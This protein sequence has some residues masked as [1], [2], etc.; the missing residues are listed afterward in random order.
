MSDRSTGSNSNGASTRAPPSFDEWH[1]LALESPFQNCDFGFKY[2]RVPISCPVRILGTALLLLALSTILS[3]QPSGPQSGSDLPGVALRKFH[4]ARTTAKQY[5]ALGQFAQAIPLLEKA[6]ILDPSNFE[7]GYD[8]GSAY[9]QTGQWDRARQEINRVVALHDSP[10]LHTLLGEIENKAG[11]R[12]AAAG[13]YQI[14]AQMEP[15]E[16]HIFDFGQ[17]LLTFNSDAAMTIF[18]YGVTKFPE[19][20][21]LRVGL[22]IAYYLYR[23]YDSAADT[24][25]QAVDMNPTDPRPIEFLGRIEVLSPE[26]FQQVN[27]RLET[28]LKLHP[29]N[30]LV[31][32]ELARN[33][34][35][36]PGKRPT[37]ED[38]VRGE[39]LLRQAIRL[40][41]RLADAYF[42]LGLI[43]EDKGQKIEARMLYENA[44]RLDASQARFHYR[45]SFVDRALGKKQRADREINRF[46]QL[47]ATEDAREGTFDDQTHKMNLSTRRHDSANPK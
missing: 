24:L 42:E 11:N 18:S 22:G 5:L 33:L 16:P 47:Q 26:K 3:A 8:L 38:A 6:R 43:V 29:E 10:E 4:S 34:L 37:S 12:Q 20:A 40:N 44:I 36:P 32:Y 15:S 28:F 30:A 41:P 19:S 13:Q 1:A 2:W 23:S 27:R 25:C 31:H 39:R 46:K 14:A 35:H 9:A 17:S 21:R 45:L 7:N